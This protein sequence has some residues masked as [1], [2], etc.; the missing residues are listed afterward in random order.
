MSALVLLVILSAVA[1]TAISRRWAHQPG[2]IV[3]VVA[4]A[5]SFIPGVP[6][7]EIDPDVIF[8]L[9]M[10]PLLYSAARQFSVF[11]FMRNLRPILVLG[12][13]LVVATAAVV[14][15]LARLMTPALGASGALILAA[16]VSPPDTVIAVQHGRA[17]GLPE[18]VVDIL[19]GE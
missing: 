6:R 16:V 9:V 12:V 10:P 5:V 2:L 15:G 19:T 3:V 1:I 11:S 7:L 4:A 8:T 17:L 18:R 13:L 14:G